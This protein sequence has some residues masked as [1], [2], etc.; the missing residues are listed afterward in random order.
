MER[1]RILI[2]D[3]HA[4]F[5]MGVRDLLDETDDFEVIGEAST[6]NE[7]VKLSKE[8]MPDLILTDISMPEGNGIVAACAIKEMLPYV[9]IVMLTVSDTE[10]DLFEAIKSGVQGYLLKNV[11]PEILLSSLRGV[12]RGEAP[13]SPKMAPK[14]LE[15]FTR[16]ADG[17]KENSASN[18]TPREK[19]VLALVAEGI[20]NKEIA[21]NLSIVESTV[22]N[23]LRNILE[24]LHLQSRAGA[25]AYAVRTGIASPLKGEPYQNN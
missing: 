8:L 9:K 19:E 21:A 22:K 13:I 18:L 12:S 24:K 17:R 23:H 4:L 25:A 20:T 2:A 15:E 10:E 6:G 11:E 1:I 7:L 16:M 5:R 3:D 14:I